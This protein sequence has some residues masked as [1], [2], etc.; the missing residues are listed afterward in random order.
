[1]A[2]MLICYTQND[3]LFYIFGLSIL[4]RNASRIALLYMFCNSIEKKLNHRN[5]ERMPTELT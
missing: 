1:M 3:A 2:P 5:E 4:G